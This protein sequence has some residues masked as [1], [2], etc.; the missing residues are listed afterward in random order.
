MVRVHRMRQPRVDAAGPGA[1]RVDDGSGVPA[2]VGGAHSNH[3]VAVPLQPGHARPLQEVHAAQHASLQHGGR[4]LA[5]VE[6]A[7]LGPPDR[8]GDVVRKS[9]F[10][11]A[12]LAHVEPPLRHRGVR[13]A[14]LFVELR[15]LRVG[16]RNEQR[17]LAAVAETGAGQLGQFHREP[18]VE[19]PRCGGRLQE[20]GV[21]W[22]RGA[23]ADHARRGPGRLA[24]GA[25]LVEQPY[26]QPFPTQEVAGRGAARA[27]ADDQDIEGGFRSH[28]LPCSRSGHYVYRRAP[29]R[30]ASRGQPC[31]SRRGRRDERAASIRRQPARPR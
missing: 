3:P 11:L 8:A 13:G 24:P 16:A 12:G 15:L 27:G 1:G 18:V 26:L 6:E 17:A 31:Y 20:P 21:A 19:L 5:R 7:V 22:R 30:L 25:L 4:I 29:R 9:R 14:G 23:G 10:A 2:P 28:C